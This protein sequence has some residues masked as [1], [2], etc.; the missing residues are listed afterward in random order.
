MT[1]RAGAEGEREISGGERGEQPG[2]AAVRFPAHG[3][4][5]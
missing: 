2:Q 3:R 1:G 5:P 4:A